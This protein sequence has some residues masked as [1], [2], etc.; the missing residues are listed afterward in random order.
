[1]N[2]SFRSATIIVEFFACV[3]NFFLSVVMAALLE[4]WLLPDLVA[5][6]RLV[7]SKDMSALFICGSS[8]EK[9]SVGGDGL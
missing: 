2:L 9:G 6:R 7:L 5:V 8:M 3:P 4:R 1:M